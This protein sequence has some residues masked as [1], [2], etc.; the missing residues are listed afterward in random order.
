MTPTEIEPQ[1]HDAQQEA[2]YSPRARAARKRVWLVMGGMAMLL[3]LLWLGDSLSSIVPSAP[4]QPTARTNGPYTVKI[5][6]PGNPTAG[7]A[8]SITAHLT[9]AKGKAITGASV[10]YEWDMVTMDMGD[11][12][13]KA[14]ASKTPGAY[15]MSVT[16]LMGGYWRLTLRM[17]APRLTDGSVQFDIPVHG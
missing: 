14:Q 10:A 17:Q 5:D 16:P 3:L 6:A 12:T 4:F 9:D 1:T 11:Y 8:M 7:Q 2:R 13:G 15:M